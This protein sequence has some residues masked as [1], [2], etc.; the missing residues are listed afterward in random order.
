MRFKLRYISRR[1]IVRPTLKIETYRRSLY[2]MRRH[3][4]IF[5]ALEKVRFLGR[6]LEKRQAVETRQK[7]TGRIRKTL[8]AY[9][10]DRRNAAV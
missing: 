8:P 5:D 1:N 4:Q 6:Q 2:E 9:G 10:K 7:A 3:Y